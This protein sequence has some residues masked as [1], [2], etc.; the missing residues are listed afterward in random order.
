MVDIKKLAILLALVSVYALA[1]RFAVPWI[2]DSLSPSLTQCYALASVILITAW[3]IVAS[4]SVLYNVGLEY[5]ADER[6]E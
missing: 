5:V 2:S 3:F 4:F 1:M 6:E